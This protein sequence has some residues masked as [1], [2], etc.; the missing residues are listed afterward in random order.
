[1]HAPIHTHAAIFELSKI[2]SGGQ[3]GVD[4][5]ALDAAMKLNFPAGG[6]CPADRKA[7]DGTIPDHYPVSPLPGAGYKER[8]RRNVLDSDATVIIFDARL[9]SGG[10]LVGGTWTTYKSCRESDKPYCVIDAG[11][12]TALTAAEK[13]LEFL[14]KHSVAM[15]NV[16]GPRHSGWSHGHDYTMS[17]LMGVI[18]R[19][20]E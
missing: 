2:I 4:R 13:V 11:S 14:R 16:A 17:T 12:T 5:G 10:R 1:M 7:E 3:T 19:I 9:T 20:L 8:T 15:L 6:W 18:R